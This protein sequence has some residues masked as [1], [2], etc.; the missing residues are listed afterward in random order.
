MTVMAEERPGA[1]ERAFQVARSG[2]VTSLADLQA[3]LAAEGYDNA[4]QL[5]SGRSLT[6]QLS[7]MIAEARS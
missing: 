5:L 2:T 3:Q 1:I 7:R 6:L 4:A